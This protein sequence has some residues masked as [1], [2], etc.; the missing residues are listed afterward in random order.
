[1]PPVEAEMVAQ[2]R[3]RCATPVSRRLSGYASNQARDAT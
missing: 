2:Q 3:C 1:M